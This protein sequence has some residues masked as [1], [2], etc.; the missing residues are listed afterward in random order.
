MFVD[1]G[2]LLVARWEKRTLVL[3]AEAVRAAAPRWTLRIDDVPRGNVDV[4]ASGA[5]ASSP[6]STGRPRRGRGPD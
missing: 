4:D 6:T 1:A 5:G 2:T 3:S